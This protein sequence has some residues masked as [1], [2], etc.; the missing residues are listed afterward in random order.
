[1]NLKH[2]MSLL[3][4]YG[5]IILIFSAMIGLVFGSIFLINTYILKRSKPIPSLKTF[6]Y[7]LFI[8]YIIALLS[9]TLISRFAYASSSHNNFAL[10]SSYLQTWHQADRNALTYLILNIMMT[11]PLGFLLPLLHDQ[12]KKIQWMLMASLSIIIFIESIQYITNRGIFDID[13]IFNNI[14]GS[15]IGYGIIMI[16]IHLKNPIKKTYYLYLLQ[17]PLLMT[18]LAFL[19]A[20]TYY[21]VKPY[22]NLYINGMP[23]ANIK[24][25]TFS[26]NPTIDLH[27]TT[28]DYLQDNTPLD[29]VPIYKTMPNDALDFEILYKNITGELPTSQHYYQHVYGEGIE[30]TS[31]DLDD[32]TLI[33]NQLDG[34]Y[35]YRVLDFTD[36]TLDV[37]EPMTTTF[38]L[39]QLKQFGMNIPEDMSG[40]LTFEDHLA[41]YQYTF[42]HQSFPNN[43]SF[44]LISYVITYNTDNT[45]KE[46]KSN[47]GTYQEVN[48]IEVKSKRTIYD[49]FI[50]GKFNTYYDLPPSITVDD[51]TLNYVTDSKNYLRPIYSIHIL[52]GD[53]DLEIWMDASKK[54]SL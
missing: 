47:N 45:L 21:Q 49:D 18:I 10:F 15:L 46:I 51:I 20:F 29:A 42:N 5:L 24:S 4:E 17:L 9:A 3:L 34:S 43:Q 25:A 33:Y 7:S 2:I 35:V 50:K 37:L 22:G 11:I 28:I 26:I 31:D 8:S 19:S 39:D 44:N 23:K 12:F 36:T 16:F 14:L 27:S 40:H 41:E 53:L 52:G 6:I 32:G 13:D 1:M 54:K 38:V 48:S 30:Y